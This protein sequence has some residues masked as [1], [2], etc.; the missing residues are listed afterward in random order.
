MTLNI[1]KVRS[2]FGLEQNKIP[3]HAKISL[4]HKLYLEFIAK[5]NGKNVSEYIR[6]KLFREF[7]DYIKE[8][9][10]LYYNAETGKVTKSFK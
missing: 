5:D 4:G 9:G 7:E 3:L 10:D 1:M 8:H 2:L 6:D